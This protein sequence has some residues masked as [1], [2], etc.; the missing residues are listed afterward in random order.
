[1]TKQMKHNIYIYIYIILQHIHTTHIHCHSYIQAFERNLR[2]FFQVPMSKDFVPP[3]KPKRCGS[4]WPAI[5][6]AGGPTTLS[7]FVP[8][9]ALIS[10]VK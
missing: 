3:G 4:R 6:L 10:G 7:M 1:M 9:A 2:S 5:V 8:I